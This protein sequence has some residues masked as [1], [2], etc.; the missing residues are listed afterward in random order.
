M[1]TSTDLFNV[2]CGHF[3]ID[4]SKQPPQQKKKNK[5]NEQIDLEAQ[6]QKNNSQQLQRGIGGLV[7]NIL[8]TN[9]ENPCVF[10]FISFSYD[11]LASNS[12]HKQKQKQ[13]K[14]H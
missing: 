13:K 2:R 11:I 3:C 6:T 5:S 14:K 12:E 9:A 10:S 8:R 7:T 4:Q 1:K